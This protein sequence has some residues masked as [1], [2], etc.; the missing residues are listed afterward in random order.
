MDPV[1]RT[2]LKRPAEMFFVAVRGA[3]VEIRA[4][5]N[6]AKSMLE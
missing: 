3:A 5:K 1:G 2:L 4:G 6:P